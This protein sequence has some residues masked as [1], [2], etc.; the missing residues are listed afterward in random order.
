MK[1]KLQIALSLSLKPHSICSQTHTG[2]HVAA[3]RTH[4]NLLSLLLS[5]TWGRAGKC[6]LSMSGRGT[7]VG[8]SVLMV[9]GEGQKRVKQMQLL[10]SAGHRRRPERRHRR[11]ESYY[12]NRRQ[13]QNNSSKISTCFKTR[14]H[15]IPIR[16][17]AT[18]LLVLF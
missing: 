12:R 10:A 13:V 5:Q 1:N 18:L 3:Y 2:H 11:Q 9:A 16:K 4:F 7:T 17:T 14:G 15:L 6:D 8:L